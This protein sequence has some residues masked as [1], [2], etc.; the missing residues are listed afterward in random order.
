MVVNSQLEFE[1]GAEITARHK[2]A[3]QAH[4]TFSAHICNYMASQLRATNDHNVL[5]PCA[6]QGHLI[7]AVL[8]T[9]ASCRIDAFEYDS[10]AAKLLQENYRS[11]PNVRVHNRDTIDFAVEAAR[12]QAVQYDRIIANP[13]YGA[14]QDYSRRDW[15]RKQFP[16]L[17]VRETYGIFLYCCINLLGPGGR[18]V[19]IIP[20]TYLNLHLHR[21]LRYH[22][23]TRTWVEEIAIFPSRFFEGIS[24][25]YAKMSI[26]TLVR[27]DSAGEKEHHMHII[28]NLR[29]PDDLSLLAQGARDGER[30][31]MLLLSQTEVL[32][33][34]SHAFLLPDKAGTWACTTHGNPTIGDIADVVTGF[35][36]GDDR[37]WLRVADETVR[38]AKNYKV[39]DKELVASSSMLSERATRY[40]I[41]GQ[42]YFVPIV[43]GGSSPFIK[44]TQWYANWGADAIGEYTRPRPN[45]ARFQNSQY[46]FREGIAVPMVSSTRV[47]AALLQ[48]RLFDQSIVAVFPH[49]SKL[50]P[51]LLGFF[52]SDVSTRLLRTINPSANNSAN[53]IKKIPF[54]RP[55]DE[56]F[57]EVA[58]IVER[59]VTELTSAGVLP[60]KQL[61]RMNELFEFLYSCRA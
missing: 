51:Y 53:Y 60:G 55:P 14:W 8:G 40:G 56:V 33:N 43:K 26:V 58:D 21:G 5:E 41:E 36:S 29:S 61:K 25:G 50:L 31:D 32:Q 48:K 20:D 2:D 17:Y 28:R 47:T 7:D 52:N 12:S 24:Y 19:F 11:N 57:T 34:P 35:Y 1:L 23:L 3:R 15:L 18:L 13:P 37:K 30:W 54:V 38:G 44:A 39:V 4:Y 46:Y 27:K 9:A 59:I 10:S 16:G 6:G 42:R 22:I 45:K 49:D